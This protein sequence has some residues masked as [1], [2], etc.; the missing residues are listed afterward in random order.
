MTFP[1]GTGYEHNLHSESVEQWLKL[2]DQRAF[3]VMEVL[4]DGRDISVLTLDQR[5]AWSRF[6]ISLIRRN[7]EKVSSVTHVIDAHLAARLGS[8]EIEY[9]DIRRPSDPHTFEEYKTRR[10]PLIC[11]ILRAEVL[12]SIVDSQVVGE[13]VNQMIWSVATLVDF[14]PCFLTSD[15]PIE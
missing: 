2:V 7:P 15:R 11:D 9:M 8:L 14:K 6:V 1:N 12:T 13:A 4:L 5:S 10:A 3:D